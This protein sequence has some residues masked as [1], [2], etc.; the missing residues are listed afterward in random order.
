[1]GTHQAVG[2]VTFF[3]LLD[4]VWPRNTEQVGDLLGGQFCV[5]GEDGDGVAGGEILEETEQEFGGEGWNLHRS[6]FKSNGGCLIEEAFEVQ[7]G[8]ARRGLV[9][10]SW[11]DV[12]DGV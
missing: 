5:N 8:L 3:D 12:V 9:V 4:D 10:G 2:E 6:A 11:S 7:H 1:M